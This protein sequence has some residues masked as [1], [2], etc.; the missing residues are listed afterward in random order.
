[1]KPTDYDPANFW[2]IYCRKYGHTGW[3]D[4]VVYQY[5]QP[6]R[7]RSMRRAISNLSLPASGNALDIGCGIGD[8][9]NLLKR[10]GLRVVGADISQEAC[11]IA[12][13]RFKKDLSVRIRCVRIENMGF[14]NAQFDLVTSVTVLQHVVNPENLCKAVRGIAEVVK[15]S[16]Y[17]VLMEST[18][19]SSEEKV[20]DASGATFL[21]ARSVDI[22]RD[23]MEKEGCILESVSGYP[24][25]GTEISLR[26]ARYLSL[27]V[28]RGRTGAGQAN[29]N[30]A[31]RTMFQ[32]LRLGI[33]TSCFTFDYLLRIPIPN[34]LS[35]LK[36]MVFRK[37][38]A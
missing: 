30:R 26:F 20:T 33:L 21:I 35:Y 18:A 24:G 36:I 15:P 16:G 4:I 6:L 2:N 7:M 23:L 17:I 8:V 3:G 12:G 32:V 11:K 38:K 25:W 10:L 1:M 13:E 37:V 34:R 19:D 9:V 29:A 27:L 14:Q 31:T 5:D 22:W 28:G